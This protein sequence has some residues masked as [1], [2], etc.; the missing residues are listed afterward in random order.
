MDEVLCRWEEHFVATHR[1]LFPHLLIADAG[2]RESFDLFAGLTLEE[3][4]ATAKV[5]DEPSFFA[6]MLPV[7]GALEA[8]QE[9]LTVGIDVALCTSPWLSNPTCASDKLRW[10]DRYLGP[11]MAEATVITRDKTRVRG[12]VLIDDKP[13]VTGRAQPEWDLVRFTYH[14]NR[15]LPG[16]RIDGWSNW[17]PVLGEILEIR[18][19]RAQASPDELPSLS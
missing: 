12:D 4:H 10:V 14:Y 13:S 18:T 17:Q 6:N 11:A 9:M 8:V 19:Q 3:Q 5:L 15:H 7:K 2:Q 1:R 16:P